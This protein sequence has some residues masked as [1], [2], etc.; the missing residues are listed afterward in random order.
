MRYEAGR[1]WHGTAWG[2]FETEKGVVP[3]QLIDDDP[4]MQTDSS[5]VEM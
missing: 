1:V 4:G 3:S 5:A 2:I